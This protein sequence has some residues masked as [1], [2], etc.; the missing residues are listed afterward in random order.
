MEERVADRVS[1]TDTLIDVTKGHRLNSILP[2][3]MWR[4]TTTDKGEILSIK[5]VTHE[6]R[7]PATDQYEVGT[8]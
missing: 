6:R 7:E 4:I 8:P 2:I 1:I 3:G 5:N